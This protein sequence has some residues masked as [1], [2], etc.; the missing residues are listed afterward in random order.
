MENFPP[1]AAGSAG[2]AGNEEENILQ[3]ILF[4]STTLQNPD[5]QW[6][7][8]QLQTHYNDGY[9]DHELWLCQ[10][11]GSSPTVANLCGNRPITAD[12]AEDAWDDLV[13]AYYTWYN[14]V[15]Q[16]AARPAAGPVSAPQQQQ[17]IQGAGYVWT[18]DPPPQP[19]PAAAPPVHPPATHAWSQMDEGALIRML[20]TWVALMDQPPTWDTI[21]DG[22]A[23]LLEEEE[24]D[25]DPAAWWTAAW[26]SSRGRIAYL[27]QYNRQRAD[28]SITLDAQ[29]AYAWQS[30]QW[31]LAD[32]QQ[33]TQNQPQQPTY[34]WTPDQP[35]GQ[36]QR[37][38]QQPTYTWTPDPQTQQQHSRNQPTPHPAPP[39]SSGQSR[40][41]KRKQP[42]PDPNFTEQKDN[43]RKRQRQRQRAVGE[44]AFSQTMKELRANLTQQQIAD[45]FGVTQNFIWRGESGSYIDPD[46]ARRWIQAVTGNPKIQEKL[47]TLY[48]EIYQGGEGGR[49]PAMLAFRERMRQLRGE[50]KFR[51][52]NVAAAVGV[53]HATIANWEG[54]SKEP[55]VESQEK[56]NKWINFLTAG[57][58]DKESVR[59]ELRRLYQKATGRKI[60]WTD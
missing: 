46:R 15:Y 60:S 43:Q 56:V 37:Y 28:A 24:I 11:Y 7:G 48:N 9:L 2:Q 14:A 10:M 49:D 13:G 36:P 42:A 47:Q 20:D 17:Q 21:T 34:T 12:E 45:R 3:A 8:H 33:Q 22:L 16:P 27:R 57:L 4:Q 29:I 38:P 26:E 52:A 53:S 39:S 19:A 51:L 30:T 59:T 25:D 40:P 18:P 41:G 35:Q 5:L 1:P 23:Q 54:G 31:A 44:N 50:G 32:Q 6:L 55:A 58:Q